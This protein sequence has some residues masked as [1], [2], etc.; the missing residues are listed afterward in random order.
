MTTH[1]GALMTEQA[2]TAAL[3]RAAIK[4]ETAKDGP[5]DVASAAVLTNPEDEAAVAEL[6][7]TTID[8]VK[9]G[10][11]VLSV[12]DLHRARLR[13]VESAQR[14]ARYAQNDGPLAA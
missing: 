9:A 14:I 1:Q 3:V 2:D 8:D 7:L 5:Q 13:A 11:H 10:M 4:H 12:L 6:Y